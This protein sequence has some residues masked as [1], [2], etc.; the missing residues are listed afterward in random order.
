MMPD[1]SRNIEVPG[2]LSWSAEAQAKRIVFLK[3]KTGV[4]I[5]NLAGH[6]PNLSA[7]GLRGN[8]EHYVGMTRVPTGIA[9]P[10]LV[11]GLFAKGSFYVPMATS[12]GALVASYNRGMKAARLSG[13]VAVR[14]LA[15]AV[16]RAPAFKFA[17]LEMAGQFVAWASAQL[18]VF[19]NIVLGQSRFAQLRN[20]KVNLEGNI[21]I[22][23]FEYTT[24]E[25]A[26]QNMATICTH[27]ICDFIVQQAP[28]KPERWYIEGNFSGDKKATVLS[29]SSVRGKRVTAEATITA[30]VIASTLRS[31]AAD[32]VH[33]WQTSVI[34][35]VQSGGI[36]L[37]G[38]FANGLAAMFL[39]TGQDVA[40]V[41]ES[42]VGINRMEVVGAA[43]LY[44]AITLPSLMIGTVGG[45]TGLPTQLECL[46]LMHCQGPDSAKK[47]AEIFAAAILS[48]ELSIAAAMAS[49]QF[50]RAHKIF[51]RKKST[52]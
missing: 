31:C 50:A 17:N 3:E 29:L 47:L 37:Q 32:M 34:S 18:G 41:A 33:Y 30:K 40:C 46:K 26:G 43:D 15:E 25:A 9:G 44:I 5:P 1:E 8:I 48:G 6:K 38:H 20:F 10:L 11:N 13:G 27:A 52:G 45:G 21:V 24:G 36:G 16:Q 49:H 2:S 7:A 42:Y 4:D 12:E 51:G 14:C 39:A 28:Q 22:L 35:A 23:V 19:Q